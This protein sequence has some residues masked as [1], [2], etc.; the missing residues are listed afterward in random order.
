[1]RNAYFRQLRSGFT[2]K[3]SINFAAVNDEKIVKSINPIIHVI[4]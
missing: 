2:E 3:T 4:S 1:M